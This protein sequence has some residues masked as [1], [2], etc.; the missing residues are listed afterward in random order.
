MAR[1]ERA[2]GTS[3]ARPR[4]RPWRAIDSN[5]REIA[6]ARTRPVTAAT[7]SAASGYAVGR[8][9]PIADAR[10]VG[11]SRRTQAGVVSP[12]VRELVVQTLQHWDGELMP[13]PQLGD[14]RS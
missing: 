8:P 2:A 12:Q 14:S 4:T 7:G 5:A 3:A 1:C 13:Q 6:H 11:G 10:T 9:N